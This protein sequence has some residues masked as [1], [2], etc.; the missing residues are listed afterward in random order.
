[1][2]K[3]L[4]VNCPT[5]SKQVAWTEDSKNRPFCSERC[6]QIDLGAWASE[7]YAVPAE[8]QDEWSLAEAVESAHYDSNPKALH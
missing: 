5:C 2:K 7:E 1:M 6:Q 4:S 8:Q 3:V